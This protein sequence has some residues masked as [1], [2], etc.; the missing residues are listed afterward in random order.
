MKQPVLQEKIQ[1][2]AT[3]QKYGLKLMELVSGKKISNGAQIE[4][5][6]ININQ[7]SF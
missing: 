6:L 7:V 2:H 3:F 5:S 4:T 1:E